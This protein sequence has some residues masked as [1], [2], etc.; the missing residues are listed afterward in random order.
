MDRGAP[1]S[2]DSNAQAV[3]YVPSPHRAQ[4]GFIV[5]CS[6]IGRASPEPFNNLFVRQVIDRWPED[7]PI[8]QLS[9]EPG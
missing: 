6:W 1:S 2:P 7:V 4:S 3:P 5:Q 8:K 9:E